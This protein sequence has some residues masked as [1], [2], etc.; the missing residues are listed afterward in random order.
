MTGN[1]RNQSAAIWF[2]PALK[3]FML[4]MFFGG[5]GV[6]YVWQQNQIHEL[7]RHIEGLENR[8]KL[9]AKANVKLRGEYAD[10]CSTIK[11]AARVKNH[12][13]LGLGPPAF[14]KILRITNFISNREPAGPERRFA[15]K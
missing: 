15:G 6:G 10:A 1:R 9:L 13:E 12:P 8:G 14:G 2:A 7:G 11:L 4:C 3:A 5:S